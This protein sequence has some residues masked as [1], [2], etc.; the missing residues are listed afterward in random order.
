VI[1][2][3]SE[4]AE[5]HEKSLALVE[6]LDSSHPTVEPIPAVWAEHKRL[7]A[8]AHQ[9]RQE[10]ARRVAAGLDAGCVIGRQPPVRR[11]RTDQ[12]TGRDLDPLHGAS[13]V[14]DELIGFWEHQKNVLAP[15]VE[16][17]YREAAERTPYRPALV[18]SAKQH[19]GL[20]RQREM[21]LSEGGVELEA[22]V[23]G[24]EQAYVNLRQSAI[25]ARD[26]AGE[27]ETR[28]ISLRRILAEAEFGDRN[29]EERDFLANAISQ[30][31]PTGLVDAGS[32]MP[33]MPG[34][35]SPPKKYAWQ[36]SAG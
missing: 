12:R 15:A 20:L 8:V 28:L 6:L 19:I 16:S 7:A 2:P 26:V 18:A 30:V 35:P 14:T 5:H 23:N 9:A 22:S 31:T 36:E 34:R 13:A 10:V 27:A 24:Y 17:S 11:V 4:S 21:M 33:M 29:T 1:D 25:D 32:G 3:E